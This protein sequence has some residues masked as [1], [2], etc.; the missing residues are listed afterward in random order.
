MQITEQEH[1]AA[2][3]IIELIAQELGKNRAIHPG[4]A[5]SSS[6][7]LSGS[8]MFRSFNYPAKNITPGTV[9]L[10]EL[11]NQKGP[12][13]INILGGMLKNMGIN[14][15]GNKLNE[16]SKAES[17]LNYLDTLILLQDK[18]GVIMNRNKLSFE[19]MAYSFAMATAFIIKECRQDLAVES[20]FNTAMYAFIEGSKTFPPEFS[21]PTTKKKG[22]FKFWK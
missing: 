13:L 17:N 18:A 21:N 7:L 8:F 5:I 11:A 4:T 6:A 14:V 9:V 2:N 1:K 15:D 12:V 19:E 10:S 16:F 20:G 3:E 22:I